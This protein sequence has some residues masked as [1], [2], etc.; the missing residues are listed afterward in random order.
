MKKLYLLVLAIVMAFA[1]GAVSQA[2]HP[3]NP[4]QGGAPAPEGA[5]VEQAAPEKPRQPQASQ[6]PGQQLAHESKQAAEGDE[7]GQFKHSPTVRW[8]A[9][10]LGISVQA[11]YWV[12]Y[13]I[14]FLIIAVLIGWA[15]KAKLPAA[16]R[17]RTASI[18]KTME[19]AQAA[20]ADANRRLSEIEGRLSKL[21]QEIAQMCASADSEAAA[22]EQRIRAAAGEE[23]RKIVE[24]AQAEI[25]SAARVAQRELKAYAAGLAITL[26]EKKM[27][28]DANTDRQLVQRFSRDLAASDGTPPHHAQNRRAPGTPE[29]TQ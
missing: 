8:V 14:D 19:E 7:S 11:E 3:S 20:S 22:E 21:D 24:S 18:R 23:S 4:S 16:F 27:Q 15:W 13:S 9:S 2:S 10:K 17:S 26:A 12:L 1:L 28:V 6:T 5:K 29:E 25:E